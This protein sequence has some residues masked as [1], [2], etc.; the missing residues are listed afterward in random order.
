MTPSL[1]VVAGVRADGW[2]NEGE[3]VQTTETGLHP[4]VSVLWRL[5]DRLSLGGSA[6]TAFRAPTLNELYRGFRVGDINT[7]PNAGLDAEKVAGFE[8]SARTNNVRVTLFNMEL[9]DTISNVTISAGGGTITRRRQNLGHTRSRGAEL[10]AE[11]RPSGDWRLSTGWLFVDATVRSGELRGK[12]VPQVPQTQA[13]PQ[14]AWRTLSGQIRWSAPQFDD[15]RN[16]LPL[17]GYI[18]AD[19]FA[20]YPLSRPVTLTLGVE[21]VLD[22]EIEVGATPVVTL[23]QPRAWSVGFRYVR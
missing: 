17:A 23:G 9:S 5:S 16:E 20:S 4:R 2:R 15:D 1:T 3:S 11:W 18:V 14:L 22:E 19:V 7:L 21:N 13:T 10:D 12:R 8:V 6:Y